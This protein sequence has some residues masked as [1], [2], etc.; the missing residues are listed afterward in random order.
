[1]LRY[2]ATRVAMVL[3]VLLAVSILTFGLVSLLPGDPALQVLGSS[4][5]SA[6]AVRQVR[7]QMGLDEPIVQR[8][9][10]WLGAALH[11]D[12]GRS[13]RTHQPVRDVLLERVPVTAELIVL[14]LLI[15]LVLAIPLGVLTA[16]RA[17]TWVDRVGS[18]T[19]LA[20][21]AAPPFMVGLALMYFFAVHLGWL[22]ATGWRPLLE[23]PVENLRHA[24]LPS[25]A[26]AAGNV[27]VFMR[28]L[29]ADMK[30]TLQED[31]VLL[32]RAKGMPTRTILFRHAMRPS[33]FSV[34][35]VL[36]IQI[37]ALIGGAV[38][39]EAIFAL[40][41]VGSLLV[42]SILTRDI[43]VVQG[44]VLVVAAVYVVANALVDL[45]YTV[46]DPRIRSEVRSGAR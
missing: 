20:L 45:A 32:A 24:L 1:M 2:L 35:T 19:S 36:G 33:L 38:V 30:A 23:D 31:H 26:L 41:G 34:L 40:P 17:N 28:L 14:A 8:Y 18:G 46:L 3:G 42:N 5:V 13:I 25:A 27:A 4:N 21:L 37:G 15:A 10:H 39:V 7:E 44:V 22:P 16:Y 9:F 11:G 43:V 12:L 29:R 6:E